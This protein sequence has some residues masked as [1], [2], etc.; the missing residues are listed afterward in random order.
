MNMNSK[1]ILAKLLAKENLTVVHGN[2][3]TAFFDLEKRKLGL[4]LFKDLDKD[5]YDLMIGHEVGHALETPLQGWHDSA[6]EIPNCP[7][8]F[9]NI[10]EDIRIEKIIQRKYPG[11][12]PVFKRGYSKLKDNDFFEISDT[13][14]N[15][16]SFMNRLNLKSKLRDLID[17]DFSAEETPYVHMAM[18]VETWDDVINTCRAIYDYLKAKQNEQQQE[19]KPQSGSGENTPESL[20]ENQQSEDQYGDLPSDLDDPADE[21]K[22]TRQQP[23]PESQVQDS[24][25]ADREADQKAQEINDPL[26]TSTDDAFRKNEE[27][28]LQLDSNNEIPIVIYGLTDSQINDILVPYQKIMESRNLLEKELYRPE[29]VAKSFEK[30][31]KETKSIVSIMAKEFELRK[32]AY[33]NA[34]ASTSKTGTLNTS[35]LH[36]YKYS[37]DIFKKVTKLADTKNHGMVMVIDQSISM[38]AILHDVIKQTLSLVSFCKAVNIPFEVYSFTSGNPNGNLLTDEI[39]EYHMNHKHVMLCQLLSSEMSKADF[40]ECYEEMFFYSVHR[41]LSR[42]RYDSLHSTPSTEVLTAMP[43]I[44]DK[45]KK[46]YN[47]QKTT[48]VLLTDGAPSPFTYKISN[49]MSFYQKKNVIINVNGVCIKKHSHKPQY[50]NGLMDLISSMEGVKTIG[51]FIAQNNVEFKSKIAESESKWASSVFEKANALM[52]TQKFLSYE[53]VLGYS[54]FFIMHAQRSK[55]DTDIGEFEINENAKASEITRAFKKFNNVKKTNRIFAVQFAE[56]IS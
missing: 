37:E 27:K 28:L 22:Q 7:R 40:E 21:S 31:Q 36:E 3:R 26:D 17:I 52:R 13:D 32:A 38:D 2:Y 33:R 12:I 4:P 35:K 6:E 24:D 29:R 19:Q 43:K 15:S 34:R 46:K 1:S 51:Y 16:M 54:K 56:T 18:S 8:A 44:L 48:F 25:M 5:V 53:N 11:L 47:I 55:F 42:S 41:F 9:I 20:S 30:F 10:I 14:V 39:E 45:F 50:C 23:D 49:E